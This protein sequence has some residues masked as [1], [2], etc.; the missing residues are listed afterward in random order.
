MRSVFKWGLMLLLGLSL[1]V[2]AQSEL[3]IKGQ[4]TDENGEPLP[5]AN[6]LVKGT[7]YGTITDDDGA[8]ILSIPAPEGEIII[9]AY[10][11]GYQTGQQTVSPTSGTVTVNFALK[12]D[13]VQG[14]EIVVT[15]TSIATARKQL[16]NAV[17]TVDVKEIRESGARSL[18]QAL[19][20]KIPGAF[21]QQNSGNPAGGISVR[22]RGTGTVLGS[23]DPLYIVDGVIVNNDSPVL[24][25]LGG[26]AQNRLVDINPED[27]E[28]IEV[29]K[30]AAAAALYGSRANNGVIQI[31]TKRGRQGRPRI[32]YSSKM[33]FN[34][35]RKKF[36]VNMYPYKMVGDS[37]VPVQRYDW[38]DFIFQTGIGNE[39]YLSVAGGTPTTSYFASGSYF[40]NEGIIKNSNFK[41]ASARI[42][43]D[44]VL[45]SWAN[46]TV[47]G[48][49]IYSWS[50]EIPNGGLASNYGALTGFIFGPNTIDPRPDPVTGKYPKPILA[51]PLE[52]IDKF[53]FNQ[54]INRFIGSAKLILTPFK[55]WSFDYTLGI[56]TYDQDATA[57]IPIGTTAPGLANGFSR[58]AKY[59]VLQLNNDVNLRYQTTIGRSIESTTL[60]GGTLQYERFQTLA[61]EA[62]DLSPVVQ[63][64]PGGATQA[65]G[66]SRGERV[67]YGF[68]AQQ[69]FG[70]KNRLFATFAGRLDASSV[71]GENERWQ[72][73]PKASFSY[74]LSEENFWKDGALGNYLPFFKLRASVGESGGLTAIGPYDRFTKYVPVSY[75]SKSG[76]IPSTQLGAEDIRPERQREVELGIDF[77]LWHNRIG[78]EFTY[79]NQ[80]TTDLLLFR[81]IAPSTGFTRKLQN[82]G[83]LKN[84]GIELLV[85]AIPVDN[86]KVRWTSTITYARNRNEVSGI[87]EDILRFSSGWGLVAAANGYPLPVLYGTRYE[88]N[89]DGSIKL[90][91]DGLPV[92]A[93]ER[94]IIGDPNP[95]WTG[96]WINEFRIMKNWSVRV[97]LDAVWG[98]DV[99]NF[100]RRLGSLFVF[101]TSKDYEKELRGELP[102][103]Y[104]RRVFGIFEH[105]VEDGSFVKLRELSL[106]YTWY[107][108]RFTTVKSVRFSLIGRNLFSW[109]NYSGFDPEVNVGGQRTVVRGF[110]F[111]E[112]PIP[113]TIQLGITLNL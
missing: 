57:F 71:F 89:P 81:T 98:Q 27:I 33:L 1:S 41:R 108:K 25:L 18:D 100:T 32:T 23:A 39:H 52:V 83:T 104:T 26:Y 70:F 56:D 77:G 49:Y 73:Y 44:Q 65:I 34:S 111:L 87:E 2:L 99:L 72:F 22:L 30:G 15:G 75:D 105:W 62:K 94:G 109:D 5:A 96:S 9:E 40:S 31:F 16:G 3:V 38:Q 21:V 35:L 11:I 68:F 28:R 50:H 6:I 74:V 46:L 85:R 66:E 55:G 69:T 14:D 106:S 7:Q 102:P 88:R 103:G 79:Y 112:V 54:R 4:V 42:R 51:N 113:R 95:D 97:Q 24:L 80:N 93:A 84:Q 53:D 45:N 17:A 64:V 59:D 61:A 20:G 10:Y 86:A 13:A 67:I 29:V 101:G 82:V 19:S 48:N 60:L 63:I 8:Y 76:L 107:P 12:L 110:D 36:P 37:L 47:S 78:V 90:D 58:H 91:A 92:R 43:V